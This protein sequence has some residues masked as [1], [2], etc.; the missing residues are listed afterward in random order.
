[1]VRAEYHG[2]SGVDIVVD[3]P[4]GVLP[5]DLAGYAAAASDLLGV[6]VDAAAAR[7]LLPGVARAV[8]QDVVDL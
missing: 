8:L 7:S 6:P 4:P 2:G 1:M 3:V 5:G